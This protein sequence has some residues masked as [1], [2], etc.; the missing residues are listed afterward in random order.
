MTDDWR[1]DRIGTALRGENPTV[2]RRLDASF[3]VIG[4]VQFLPGYSVLL[5]DDPDVRRL[6]ELPRARRLTFLTEMDRLGEAVERACRRLDPAFRRVNLEIL[7]NTDPFLHAHVWPRFDWEPADLVG[8]PVWLYP[9]DRWSDERF[10]LG[11]RH[12]A[13]RDAIGEELD[14]LRTTA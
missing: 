11:P 10:R 2:L 14:R 3:A 7:G 1:K 12:G 9:P 4:D 13:L 8:K 5:V 6:S